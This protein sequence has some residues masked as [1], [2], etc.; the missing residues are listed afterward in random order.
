VAGV[1]AAKVRKM[2]VIR[3]SP[4][5]N[6]KNVGKNKTHEHFAPAHP[7]HGIESSGSQACSG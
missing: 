3:N 6:P 7:E 5:K 4:P 1:E 2:K